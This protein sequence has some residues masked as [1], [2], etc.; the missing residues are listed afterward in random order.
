MDLPTLRALRTQEGQ[1][2]RAQIE[3]YDEQ[4]ALALGARLRREHPAALVAAAMTQAR[5]RARAHG[6]FGADAARMF[7]TAAGLEQ[8]TRAPVARHRARR[9]AAVG[10][11]AVRVADLGC[12]IGSDAVALTRAGARVLAVERDPF[13]AEVARANAEALGLADRIEV[14]CADVTTLPAE[15]L[16]GCHAAF[17]DPARRTARGRV[18]AP[19]SWSPPWSRPRP[20]ARPVALRAGRSRDP[21]RPGGPRRAR[22]RR[23]LLDP[24]IAYVTSDALVSTTYAPPMKCSTCWRSRSSGCGRFCASAPSGESWCR[25]GGRPWTL[26]RCG[27]S[28]ASPVTGQSSRS[29]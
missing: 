16:A 12:G 27:A 22:R 10:S 6:K 28:C 2:L 11:G 7:F 23:G 9:F 1:A 26:T 5:L 19:E 3:P 18:F 25:S 4:R 21:R 29:S 8:A 14:R 15:A 17:C 24:T 13:T 20:P